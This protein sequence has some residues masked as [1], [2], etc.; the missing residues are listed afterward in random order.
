MNARALSV[1]RK[2]KY[3]GHREAPIFELALSMQ[4]DHHDWRKLAQGTFLY[5]PDY[6]TNLRSWCL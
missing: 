1:L 3:E 5:T 4:P 6:Y 2:K